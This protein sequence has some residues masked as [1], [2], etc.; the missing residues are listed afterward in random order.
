V[1]L[2]LVVQGK[3]EKLQ[4]KFF[5]L[6]LEVVDQELARQESKD[7][8]VK[9]TY[10]DVTT[11]HIG[12][13]LHAAQAGSALILSTQ[14]DALKMAID[15][16][17][18][19]DKPS[20]ADL[21]GVKEARKLLPANPLG[22]GWINLEVVHRI[23]QA[24]T[25]L[26]EKQDNIALTVSVGHYLDLVRRS[27]FACAGVYQEGKNFAITVRLPRGRE[28]MP[29]KWAAYQLPPRGQPATLPLLEPR[30]VILS[31]SSYSDIGQ[32]WHKRAEF[33]NEN[34]LKTFEQFDKNSGRFLGGNRLSKLLTSAGP[35]ERFVVVQQTRPGYKSR[36]AQIFPAGA[37]VIDMREPDEFGKAMDTVLRAA[38]LLAGNQFNLKL[39]EE[40]K[41]NTTIVGYRF[42]EATEK[43]TGVLQNDTTNIRYNVSPCFVRVGNQFVISSTMELASELVDL[44]EKEAKDTSRK[45]S[46]AVSRIQL[47]AT[48]GAAALRAFK[49][50]LLTQTILGQAVEPDQAEKQ[51]Q[52]FTNLVSRLGVIEIVQ[53]IARNSYRMDIRWKLGK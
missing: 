40:K 27:P 12:K 33:F 44:L 48:G 38:A 5:T 22:W 37:F 8:P 45:G 49:D 51:V 16:H 53:N 7:R 41:G 15:R 17:L 6:A 20:V 9:D 42:P 4:Q 46:P 14:P 10:R 2:V 29:E 3:D 1:P 11:V 23:P 28:G 35:H 52:A 39:V 31:T 18:E 34:Q 43:V 30:N 36:P 47:Y 26:A 21:A 13:G 19:C 32:F 50:Q 24:K 25:L